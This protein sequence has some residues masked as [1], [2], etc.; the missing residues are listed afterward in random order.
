MNTRVVISRSA[1]YV[2]AIL[3]ACTAFLGLAWLASK[4]GGLRPYELPLEVE[5]FLVLVVA[6]LFQPFKNLIQGRMD[7]Y[8][9]R[10]SYDYQQTIRAISREM[11]K[12]LDLEPLLTFAGDAIVKTVRP[13]WLAVYSKDV[14]TDYFRQV[15]WINSL[16]HDDAKLPEYIADL[17]PLIGLLR[18]E[19]RY[20]LRDEVFRFLTPQRNALLDDFARLDGEFIVPILEEGQVAGFFIMG[21]K[22]SG[23]PFFAE[24]IDLLTTLVSQASI[25]IKNAQLY[26]QVVLVNDYIEN[27]IETMDSGVI[28]V[29][30]D[31][32]VTLFNS[33]AGR[34]THLSPTDA[35]HSGLLDLPPSIAASLRA[36]SG[37]TRPRLQVETVVKDRDGRSVPIICSTSVLKDRRGSVLGAVAV[38][39]DLSRL[40]ELE[41]DKR[42]AE[43]LASIGALAS[44]VAH[45]IKNPLVAI[46]TFA[47]LL[48]ERFNE[49]DFRT[50]FARVMIREIAR[51][52]DLVARLR[53][54]AAPPAQRATL[55]DLHVPVQDTLDLLR[56]QFDQNQI[57]VTRDFAAAHRMVRGDEAQ[58]KQ[59][60]LNLFMNAIE[61]MQPGGQLFIRMRNREI[62]ASRSLVVEISDSGPGIPVDFIYMIF[63]KFIK[64]L[65]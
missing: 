16:R 41:E 9:F 3:A 61:A 18:H 53:G 54:L 38:F 8:F 30:A 21:P 63:V 36:T 49:E 42:R 45:E 65:L 25:A 13:E 59:L 17:S 64:S 11:S 29:A 24:D 60:F 55:L 31:G 19:K 4:T 26:S 50:D 10:E 37:D 56:A 46:K 20:I 48:P 34:M 57:A 35:K 7:S 28:A 32:K 52:D 58:L 62:F 43:R 39:S 6:V 12:L 2:L 51:I 23:D 5:L 33:A 44:G 27:I 47:E 1:T 40:K 14:G 22:S 15:F